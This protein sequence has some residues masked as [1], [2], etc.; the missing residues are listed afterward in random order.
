LVRIGR[1]AIVPATDLSGADRAVICGDG[2]Q[3]TGPLP[4]EAI[5]YACDALGRGNGGGS[6]WT[7]NGGWQGN[8]PIPPPQVI[9][10]RDL[11]LRAQPT[12]RAVSEPDPSQYQSWLSPQCCEPR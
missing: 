12:R 11:F 7:G 9:P 8:P 6:G 1:P 3:E 5:A 4:N 2:Q 10:D